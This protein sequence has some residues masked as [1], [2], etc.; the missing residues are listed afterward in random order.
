MGVKPAEARQ[1]SVAVPPLLALATHAAARVKTDQAGVVQPEE[2]NQGRSRTRRPDRLETQSAFMATAAAAVL[3]VA[4]VRERR[5]PAALLFAALTCGFG[6][7]SFALATRI[8]SLAQGSLIALGSLTL[9]SSLKFADRSLSLPDKRVAAAIAVPALLS[10]LLI[11]GRVSEPLQSGLT[12]AWVGLGLILGSRELGRAG[13]E[14]A[15]GDSPDATRLRYLAV[16]QRIVLAAIV[17]D[18]LAWQLEKPRSAVLIA[19]LFYLY[20]GFLHLARIRVK[21]LRQLMGNT[22]ALTLLA[23]GL[24]GTFATLWLWVGT[25]LDAFVFNA[26]VASFVLLL[27]LEP[28]KVRIQSLMDRYF[29][30]GR[31]ALERAFTPL[32]ERL[33]HILTLDEFLRE[34]LDAA[35]ATGRLRASAIYLRDDPHVGFQPVGS[36]GLPARRRVHLIRA[37]AWAS[38]LESGSVLTRE[39]LEKSCE[40]PRPGEEPATLRALART[41]QELDAQL[42]LPLRSSEHLVGF[43]TLTDASEREPFSSTEIQFLSQVAQ[44]MG[45]TIENTKTFERVRA[46]D[47][48]AMLGE[49][50]AGLAHEIRNPLATIRGSVALLDDPDPQA[51]AEMRK[52]MIEEIDRLDRLVD[53]FLNYAQPATDHSTITNLPDLVRGCIRQV[54]R[55]Q[56]ASG[57]QLELDCP[58]DLPAVTANAHQLERVIHNVLQNALEA[59]DGRGDIAVRVRCVESDERPNVEILVSDSGPGLDEATLERA[60]IPFFTTKHAGTGLGL[61]LCERLMRAQGGAIH[62]SSKPGER[63]E[64]RIQIPAANGAPT[65]EDPPG[66]SEAHA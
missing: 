5:D 17:V 4:I 60:F 2:K 23:A 39:D 62:L 50:S 43:W 3:W 34:V 7:W 25:R 19:S 6:V 35:E 47:R 58:L 20:A 46:R 40:N 28:A 55:G 14:V 48:F 57:I 10:A 56:T 44:R 26:F 61:P 53:T 63:T 15:Q 38:V 65:P 36:F 31:L 12:C 9:L 8:E 42:V 24:A 32:L 66:S 33:P 54:M 29:V 64:V 11:S 16:A 18:V 59:L 13:R 49:M 21:D 37:P 30:A 41:I 27:F 51:S 45:S 22:V 52:V 1:C